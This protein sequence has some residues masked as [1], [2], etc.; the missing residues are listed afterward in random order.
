MLGNKCTNCTSLLYSKEREEK[1][2]VDE[3]FRY[4]KNKESIN[5]KTDSVPWT[6]QNKVSWL[7]Y[8]SSYISRTKCKNIIYEMYGSNGKRMREPNLSTISHF[9]DLLCPL[10]I[11]SRCAWEVWRYCG[12]RRSLEMYIHL[13]QVWRSCL[14]ICFPRLVF[15]INS[16]TSVL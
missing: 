14:V 5:K 13:L 9:S 12:I 1:K 7:W 2:Y 4:D 6:E 11:I 10:E 16:V 8:N 15:N 3:N